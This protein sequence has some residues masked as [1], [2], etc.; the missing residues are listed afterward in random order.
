MSAFSASPSTA[1]PISATQWTTRETD[2]AR[3]IERIAAAG[4]DAIELAADPAVDGPALARAVQDAGLKVSSLCAMYSLERDCAAADPA[5]RAAA[6]EYV[7]DC[8]E[9]ADAVGAPVVVVV[10]SYRVEWE[11][12]R[13]AELDRAAETLASVAAEISPGGPTL[14]LEALN[15]YEA[16]LLKNLDEAEELRAMIDHPRVG[17]MADV[18]HMNIEEDS[19][20]GAL[21]KHADQI[22]H[23]HLA[24]NQRRHP[25]SGELDFAAAFAALHEGGYAG[26]LAM[27]FLPA[28]DAALA[29]GL[30]HVRELLTPA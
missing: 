7:R 6:G 23:V 11:Y 4:Y 8:L 19:I 28:T 25:G 12:D 1:W 27:E 29:A 15:R 30:V 26:A 14:A 24:D 22:V 17:L 16:H 13:P 3:A 10:P 21:R 20:A 9:L 2:P 18:F 5:L